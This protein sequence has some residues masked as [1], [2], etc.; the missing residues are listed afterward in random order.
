[1]QHQHTLTLQFMRA[2]MSPTSPAITSTLAE[3]C[4][5]FCRHN[6]PL[7]HSSSRRIQSF[8]W[9]PSFT[10]TSQPATPGLKRHCSIRAYNYSPLLRR[11]PSRLPRSRHYPISQLARCRRRFPAIH[12]PKLPQRHLPKSLYTGHRF[13]PRESWNCGQYLLGPGA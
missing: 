4:I 7:L 5:S 2:N 13:I 1:M 12:E 8:K 6:R 10:S 9:L 11:V 3:T